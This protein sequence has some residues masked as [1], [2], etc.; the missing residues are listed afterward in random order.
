MCGIFWCAIPV[1]F[2]MP[3]K[4]GTIVVYCYAT[5][6]GSTSTP[7]AC[8][9]SFNGCAAYLNVYMAVIELTKSAVD[10]CESNSIDTSILA[11]DQAFALFYT[12]MVLK[13][14]LFMVWPIII[15][16]PP[17]KLSYESMNLDC[18]DVA[19]LIDDD[20]EHLLKSDSSGFRSWA[21][22]IHWAVFAS[23]P[24]GLLQV[25]YL[26]KADIKCYLLIYWF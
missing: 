17:L 19:G 5:G 3:C 4:V 8:A 24:I 21:C 25:K 6:G 12:Y 9:Y 2:C 22:S 10:L 15:N 16:P 20:G 18:T 14:K 1:N 11:W 23:Q 13:L 7:E 26:W